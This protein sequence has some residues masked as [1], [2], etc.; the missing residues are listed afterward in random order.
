MVEVVW[1]NSGFKSKLEHQCTMFTRDL[2]AFMQNGYEIY[3]EFGPTGGGSG[4]PDRG[5]YAPWVWDQIIASSESLQDFYLSK[6]I[7]LDGAAA[8]AANFFTNLELFNARYDASE[9]GMLVLWPRRLNRGPNDSISEEIWTNSNLFPVTIIQH[10]KPGSLA[11]PFHQYCNRRTGDWILDVST[12]EI[13]LVEW[14]YDYKAPN[15]NVSPFDYRPSSYPS[16]SSILY[17]ESNVQYHP[18][19]LVIGDVGYVAL[20][21]PLGMPL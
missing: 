18:K 13:R 3:A 5:R 20:N 16:P 4:R 10:F 19:Y 1:A 6:D 2:M 21:Y 11:G 9:M 15:P 17:L 7:E 12:G 8:Q 14:V